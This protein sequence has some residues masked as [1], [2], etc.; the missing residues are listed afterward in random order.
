M[1][2]V[3]VMRD[4][5]DRSFAEQRIQTQDAHSFTCSDPHYGGPQYGVTAGR[6]AI[7]GPAVKTE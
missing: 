6:E 2:L 5:L 3:V 7:V 4:P 1:D